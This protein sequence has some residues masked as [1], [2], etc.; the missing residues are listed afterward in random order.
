LLISSPL[1]EFHLAFHVS[2]IRYFGKYSSRI[3]DYYRENY[4]NNVFES[5]GKELVL[6]SFAAQVRYLP[7]VTVKNHERLWHGSLSLI[8]VSNRIS[9]E[10]NK[11]N[12]RLSQ[13]VR[14]SWHE[15]K[16]VKKHVINIKVMELLV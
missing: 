14:F 12:Y 8:P 5:I 2:I 9:P 13:I 4:D 6:T 15:K 16:Y 1:S 7:G 10:Y 3:S 11:L